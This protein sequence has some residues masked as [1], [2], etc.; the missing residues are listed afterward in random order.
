M[1]LPRTGRYSRLVIN[2]IVIPDI[3]TGSLSH[4]APRITRTPWGNDGF[5]K[6]YGPGPKTKTF[7]ATA[8]FDPE[9]STAQYLLELAAESD[10]EAEYKLTNVKYY[11]IYHDDGTTYWEPDPSDSDAGLVVEGYDMDDPGDEAIEMS[12]SC[13]MVGKWRRVST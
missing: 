7:T 6:D 10:T 12:Y 8:V 4:S 3:T 13:R 1:S 5:E 2:D 11:P 9:D